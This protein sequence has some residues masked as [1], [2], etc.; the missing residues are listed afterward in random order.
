[1]STRTPFAIASACALSCGAC[2]VFTP[3]TRPFP[4]E[5]A[6][7]AG[8]GRTGEQIELARSWDLNADSA[9]LRVR[10]GLARD[11]DVSVEAAGIVVAS[12]GNSPRVGDL[13]I[14]TGRAGV[15]QR[16]TPWLAVGGGLGGGAFGDD[17]FLGP[18]LAAIASYEN[19]YVVPFVAVR[20][21]VSI[22]LSQQQ[23]NFGD[24]S[25]TPVTEWYGHVALGARVP[26]GCPEPRPGEAR[27]SLLM[28]YSRNWTVDSSGHGA[29]D[30]FAAGAEITF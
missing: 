23:V 26:V 9:A 20:G 16:L 24:Q 10:H 28:G 2:S 7:T 11:T 12:D 13:R 14:W 27:G 18:D 15:K 21:A 6:A 4:L 19:P 29:Y 30:A 3:P 8:K 25:A 1:M 22:P 17:P 5:T